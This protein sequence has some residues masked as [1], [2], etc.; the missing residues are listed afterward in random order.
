[1]IYPDELEKI[2][3][4]HVTKIGGRTLLLGIYWSYGKIMH[5]GN[6]AQLSMFL[7]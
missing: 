1:M 2:G 5:L 7:R 4:G 3:M 6:H